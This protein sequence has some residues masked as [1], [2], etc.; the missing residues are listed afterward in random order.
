[1]HTWMFYVALRVTQRTINGPNQQKQQRGSSCRNLLQ[2][3]WLAS[4][5]CMLCSRTTSS[6]NAA[7]MNTSHHTHPV[8]GSGMRVA[9]SSS[10]KI[11]SRHSAQTV[12]SCQHKSSNSSN[13]TV[14]KALR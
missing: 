1:M 2:S 9:V 12:S 11:K 6:S 13:Q 4:Q 5:L 7:T 10:L 3:C 8:V 14:L